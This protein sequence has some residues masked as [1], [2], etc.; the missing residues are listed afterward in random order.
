MIY[1]G[2]GSN[3]NPL[4]L[5]A[6]GV[7]PLESEPA[8]LRGWQLEFSVTPPFPSQGGM[9]TIVPTHDPPDT[10]HGVLHRCDASAFAAI[11]AFE[12]RGTFYDRVEVDAEPYAGGSRRAFAYVALP[13][14]HDRTLRPTQRYL[15][16]LLAGAETMKLDAGYVARVSLTE[17]LAPRTWPEFQHP[18]QPVRRFDA[19]SLAKAEKHVALGGAVFDMSQSS[20][21][22]GFLVP[23]WSGKDVTLFLL[24]MLDP[25]LGPETLDRIKRNELDARQRNHITGY[26]H[27]MTDAFRYAGRYD[28]E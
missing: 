6:K 5:R 15:N 7:E 22:T 1:F 4:G 8:L 21:K 10:V 3:L 9:A 23:M 28:Y 18:V 13:R 12:A 20:W 11:D 17:T 14:F 16:N 19:A 27:E 25:G 26:M 2:Y 24:K